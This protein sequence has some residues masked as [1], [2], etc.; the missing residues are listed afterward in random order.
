MTSGSGYDPIRRTV[1]FLGT[2]IGRVAWPRNCTS[3]FPLSHRQFSPSPLHLCSFSFFSWSTPF[4]S[5]FYLLI[6]PPYFSLRVLLFP[7]FNAVFF[8]N[9]FFASLGPLRRL[10]TYLPLRLTPSLLFLSSL[11][12]SSLCYLFACLPISAPRHLS[13]FF[14]NVLLEITGTDTPSKNATASFRRTPMSASSIPNAYFVIG[15]TSGS[16]SPQKTTAK[17]SMNGCTTEIPATRHPL[18]RTS[19]SIAF[20]HIICHTCLYHFHFSRSVPVP[21]TTEIPRAP[22][23]T[24]TQLVLASSS[25]TT[26]AVERSTLSSSPS[27]KPPLTTHHRHTNDRPPPHSHRNHPVHDHKSN[28]NRDRDHHRDQRHNHQPHSPTNGGASPSPSFHDL[29][30]NNFAPIQES[31]RRNAEQRA[32]TLRADTLIGEVEPN[33]VFCSLC[34]KWVQLRQDSSFCAYPWLQHRGKC[35]ARQ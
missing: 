15:V 21:P 23:L 25:S 14:A 27:P 16:A 33:R 32:A 1:R 18:P 31:R 29:N 28:D 10:F 7:R 24:E 4:S 35:L 9:F 13:D 5:S 19:V 12:H 22:P 11:L 8:F 3:S 2:P 17:P 20:H 26:T 6:S 34:Q 30:P